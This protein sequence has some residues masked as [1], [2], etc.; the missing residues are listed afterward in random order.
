MVSFIPEV[1]ELLWIILPL[2][3]LQIT[4]IVASIWQWNRKR[5]F[6]GQYKIIWLLIIIFINILGPII[7]LIYSQRFYL[8]GDVSEAETDEWRS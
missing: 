5:E 8:I 7:F 4:L 3:V 6:I 1:G 2:F